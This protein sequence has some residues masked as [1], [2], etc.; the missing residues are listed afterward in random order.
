MSPRFLLKLC[1]LTILLTSSPILS[2]ADDV[3]KEF[4]SFQVGKKKSREAQTKARELYTDARAALF[5][6]KDQEAICGFEEAIRIQPHF[7]WALMNVDEYQKAIALDP[8][9]SNYQYSLGRAYPWTGKLSEAK[10]AFHSALA[11]SPHHPFA[12]FQLGVIS[13]QE[14][15]LKGALDFY[16]QGLQDLRFIKNSEFDFSTWDGDPTQRKTRLGLL[17][18]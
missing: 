14:G 18:G 8:S 13:S 2:T 16:R 10:R 6:G 5:A 9:F 1:L 3:T 11:L 15:N 17:K 4:P 7:P 12:L